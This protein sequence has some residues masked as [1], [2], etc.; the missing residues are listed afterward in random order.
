MRRIKLFLKKN[1]QCVFKIVLLTRLAPV[2]PDTLLSYTYGL[3]DVRVGKYVLATW[4]GMLPSTIA[5]VYV[6][7]VM[8]SIADGATGGP[9]GNLL[10]D[11]IFGVGLVITVVAMVVIVRVSKRALHEAVNGNCGMADKS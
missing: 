7:S 3:T 6:G 2:F 5:D 1:Q 9:K 11:V 8:E 10:Q 4:I